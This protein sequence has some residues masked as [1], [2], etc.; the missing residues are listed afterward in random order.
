MH[1]VHGVVTPVR[2]G[3]QYLG[4]APQA[5][6]ISLL[7]TLLKDRLVRMWSDT[8]H[9]HSFSS[10]LCHYRRTK[11]FECVP[12]ADRLSGLEHIYTTEK[13]ES[14]RHLWSCAGRCVHL[15]TP[16]S[17]LPMCLPYGSYAGCMLNFFNNAKM[18]SK[19]GVP[20]YIPA[21]AVGGFR[22]AHPCQH[23]GQSIFLIL[24]TLLGV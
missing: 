18:C 13:K 1:R 10:W 24:A 4:R 22:K 3:K 14:G 11:R 21:Y 16:L 23:L 5:S 15:C 20:F 8:T 9:T 7:G 19:I 12:E 17:R 6:A 2:E